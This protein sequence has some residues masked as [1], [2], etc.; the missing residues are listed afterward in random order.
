M[1]PCVRPNSRSRSSGVRIWRP[2][3]IFFM[4]GACSAKMRGLTGPG[5]EN[6]E[7][8]KSEIDF[9][10]GAAEFVA[11]DTFEEV[12]GELAGLK[13][14]FEGE[15]RVDAG[16]DHIG[17]DFFAGLEYDAGRAAVL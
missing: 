3:I 9:A 2:M 15:M 6:G 4:L 5:F 17:G 1:L 14:F 8:V 12:G 13:K 11:A 7:R 16:G 10:G